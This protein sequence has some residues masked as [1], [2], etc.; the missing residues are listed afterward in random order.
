MDETDKSRIMKVVFSVMKPNGASQSL[1]NG[2]WKAQKSVCFAF[3]CFGFSV[4][5]GAELV[6]STG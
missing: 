6:K 5:F 3:T 2:Q 1:G 4:D